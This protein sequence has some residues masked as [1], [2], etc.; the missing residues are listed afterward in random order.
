MKDDL[1]NNLTNC[2]SELFTND[3]FVLATLLDSRFK[4]AFFT[5]SERDNAKKLLLG[6]IT[7]QNPQYNNNAG[8]VTESLPHKKLKVSEEAHSSF[9]DCFTE[10]ADFDE[11][12]KNVVS[13]DEDSIEKLNS[14]FTLPLL[15]RKANPLQ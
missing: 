2:F 14:Y 15:K 4:A 10:I 7:S 12:V 8:V 3:F 13:K 6:K 5:V 11:N 9:W 1:K